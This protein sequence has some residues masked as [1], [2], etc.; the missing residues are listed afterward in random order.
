M[1][2]N[3]LS[4]LLYKLDVPPSMFRLNGEHHELAFVLAQ[5]DAGWVVFLSERGEESAPISFEKEW[6]AS[7]FLLGQ[8]CVELARMKRLRVTS[9]ST[10]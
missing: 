4:A 2:R 1:T 10:A 3:E 5:R 7:A 8:V 6:D 9:E